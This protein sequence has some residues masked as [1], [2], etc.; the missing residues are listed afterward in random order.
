M[1]PHLV[2][3]SIKALP[4]TSSWS[5][6]VLTAN[7]CISI[8]GSKAAKLARATSIQLLAFGLHR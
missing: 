1:L 6:T 8:P 4:T 5:K 2:Y 3:L 7:E